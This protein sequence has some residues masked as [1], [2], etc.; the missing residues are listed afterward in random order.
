MKKKILSMV[1]AAAMVL[2][3]SSVSQA[4]VTADPEDGTYKITVGGVVETP[5]I[6]VTL[7][8]SGTRKV[9]INP[10]GL[11]TTKAPDVTDNGAKTEYLVNSIQTITNTGATDL[12]VNVTLSAGIPEGSTSKAK[13]ATAK[14]LDTDKNNSVFAFLNVETGSTAKTSMPNADYDKTNKGQ[15]V[16]TSKATTTKE[17]AKLKK[18]GDTI[19]SYKIMGNVAQNPTTPWAATDVL[20]FKI[21]FDFEPRVYS[22]TP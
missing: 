12:A 11:D 4:A 6:A 10:Y 7:T 15:A 3:V 16:F 22:T 1:M 5:T 13:L 20:D 14:V 9:V 17:I 21:V 18:T 8:D 19:A 2:S